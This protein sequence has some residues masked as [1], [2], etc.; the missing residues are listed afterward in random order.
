MIRHDAV[1]PFS[2]YDSRAS[3]I[4]IDAGH[5]TYDT[6]EFGMQQVDHTLFVLG[7]DYR[8]IKQ[9][10]LCFRHGLHACCGVHAVHRGSHLF[11]VVWVTAAT[12]IVQVPA[13][14]QVPESHD[15]IKVGS[16]TCADNVEVTGGHLGQT[17]FENLFVDTE[18]ETEIVEQFPLD[19]LGLFGCC[20]AVANQ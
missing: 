20:W 2:L 18:V 11:V 12:T 5:A 19:I 14:E 15:V 1:R 4:R 10:L 6:S 16:P 9:D 8:I 3:E 17:L 13:G 7:Q